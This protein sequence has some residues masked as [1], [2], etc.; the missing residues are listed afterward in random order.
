MIVPERTS[1]LSPRSM[2]VFSLTLS[3]HI[4]LECFKRHRAK[5]PKSSWL[6]TRCLTRSFNA[7]RNPFGPS[8]LKGTSGIRV[9]FTSWFATV[10]LAAMNPACRPMS[11]TRAKPL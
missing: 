2:H 4:S 9:K 11:F 7:E 8:S 6:A 1:C 5:R 3:M 10:A